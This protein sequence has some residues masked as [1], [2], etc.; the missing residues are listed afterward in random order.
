MWRVY[1]RGV[2]MSLKVKGC[3]GFIGESDDNVIEV[4]R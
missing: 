3:G 1:W 2:T 4:R